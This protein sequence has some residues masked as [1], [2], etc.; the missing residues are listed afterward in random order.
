MISVTRRLMLGTVVATVIARHWG[1]I[2]A[3]EKSLECKLC[4]DNQGC[5]KVC[6]LVQEDKKVTTT[7]WGYQCEDFCAPGPSWPGDEQCEIVHGGNGQ[8]K[9]PCSVAKSIRWMHWIPGDCGTVYTKKKLMKKT[10]TKTVPGYKW[11][12]E[13]LCPACQRR[14]CQMS[15]PAGTELPPPPHRAG[16]PVLAAQVGIETTKLPPSA[17]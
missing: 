11:V 16:V 12:V 2:Q 9:E 13:D 6:R 4:S 5:Q 17:K 8:S 15:I 14:C 10:V 1:C 3:G 7:C